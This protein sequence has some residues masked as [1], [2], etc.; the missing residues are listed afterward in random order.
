MSCARVFARHKKEVVDELL[1]VLKP[2]HK[3]EQKDRHAVFGTEMS[4][5]LCS[6]DDILLHR[7]NRRI[8][9]S[10]VLISG[11]S[12]VLIGV[13]KQHIESRSDVFSHV[14]FFVTNGCGSNLAKILARGRAEGRKRSWCRTHK[15]PSVTIGAHKIKTSSPTSL[16][17]RTPCDLSSLSRRSTSTTTPQPCHEAGRTTSRTGTVS[18][19]TSKSCTPRLC[20]A[21]AVL[22]RASPTCRRKH[23]MSRILYIAWMKLRRPAGGWRAG[24]RTRK[25]PT[26]MKLLLSANHCCRCV[27]SS[28]CPHGKDRLYHEIVNHDVT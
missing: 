10:S 1:C 15:G 24:E 22:G 19:S 27:M 12:A 23:R 14:L 5:C 7:T 26:P 17:L 28:S 25:C 8:L 2:K 3:L 13:L 21:Y 6:H 4:T 20:S 18:A 16:S 9:G 11:K